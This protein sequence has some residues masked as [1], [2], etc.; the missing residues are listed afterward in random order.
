[1]YNKPNELLTEVNIDFVD[2]TEYS[3]LP[4]EKFIKAMSWETG[5]PNSYF[6]EINYDLRKIVIDVTL[7][8]GVS[9]ES[10]TTVEIEMNI[11]EWFKN[12]NVWDLN[13][14]GVDLMS[15]YEAQKMMNENGQ[16]VFSLGN[17]S[18]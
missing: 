2:L 11:A 17:V 10:N 15:N 18:L 14:F 7:E 6:D 1:M 16:T 3:I 9:L 13:T 12:P 5:L 8:E 4:Y